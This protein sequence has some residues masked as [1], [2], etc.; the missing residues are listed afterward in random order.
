MK[1]VNLA[2]DLGGTRVRAALADGEDLSQRIEEATILQGGPDGVIA[3]VVALGARSLEQAGMSWRDVGCLSVASPG[4]LNTQTGVVFSPPNLPGW[5]DV[6]L[7]AELEQRTG[8][9][10]LVVNDANAAGLGEFHFGAGRGR[11]S[12]IYLTVSTGIGGG[13]IID[14]ALVEGTS[15]T[16]GEIGHM[17]IDLNG[18]RCTCGNTGCLEMLASGTSIARRFQERQTAG[19]HSTLKA[20]PGK[21]VSAARIAAAAAEGDP[22]ASAVWFD[23]MRALGFGVVNCIHIFNPEIVAIGGGVSAAGDLFFTPIRDIVNRYAL[24]VPRRDV[25]VVPAQL[26][27]DVGLVGA[28]AFARTFMD[29]RAIR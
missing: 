18:P 27:A 4:P 13:V 19:E 26:G 1:P 25:E 7:K 8:V 2:I 29:A 17:T 16:A 24:P 21:Q 5:N 20:E 23:A 9:S 22:L 28:A 6:P 3:Q 15:G 14:G 11:R 12:M 10:V